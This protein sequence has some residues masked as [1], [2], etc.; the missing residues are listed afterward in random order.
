MGKS[1]RT[2]QSPPVIENLGDGTYYYNFDVVETPIDDD[3][4]PSTEEGMQYDYEQV[5]C[6]YPVS[7]E[8]IQACVDEEGYNHQVDLSAYEEV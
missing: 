1:N 4:D 8:V 5:R 6:E 3:N 7:Q 2:H